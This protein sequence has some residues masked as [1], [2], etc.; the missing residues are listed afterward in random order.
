MTL[1]SADDALCISVCT[2]WPLAC[3][4]ASHRAGGQR[5]L[6]SLSSPK[7]LKRAAKFMSSPKSMGHRTSHLTTLSPPPPHPSICTLSLFPLPQGALC[8]CSIY[9]EIFL[10]PLL[11]SLI[12]PSICFLHSSSFPCLRGAAMWMVHRHPSSFSL[13]SLR[14]LLSFS[15]EKY[16]IKASGLGPLSHVAYSDQKVD[17]LPPLTQWLCVM[18]MML[19][20]CSF[21]PVPQCV[22]RGKVNCYG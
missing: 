3:H 13:L 2:C 6:I 19:L 8:E 12:S 1:C 15:R 17:A 16:C 9:S 11:L 14:P 21:C 7:L 10:L 18:T 22:E 4:T 20:G 5:Q